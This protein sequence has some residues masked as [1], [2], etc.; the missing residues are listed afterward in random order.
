MQEEATMTTGTQKV[1]Q[2]LEDGQQGFAEVV[3]MLENPVTTAEVYTMFEDLRFTD[4]GDIVTFMAEGGTHLH[5]HMDEIKEVRF[6]HRMNEQG[7]PSYSVWFMGQDDQPALR[8]YL[9]KSEKAE[10][11]QPRHDLFMRLKEKYGETLRLDS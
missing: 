9:R 2:I 6:I 11:N 3:L 10:T 1:R 5:M 7:L 8:V 4:K